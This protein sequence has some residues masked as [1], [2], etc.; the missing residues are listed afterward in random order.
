[1]SSENKKKLFK[2]LKKPYRFL[3]VNEN[4]FEERAS[5][6]LTPINT[7]LLFSLLFLVFFLISYF[8]IDRSMVG[9]Y[10]TK[11]GDDNGRQE[12]IDIKNK[13]D[14]M[15]KQNRI[16][17]R[18]RNDIIKVLKGEK[19]KLDTSSIEINEELIGEGSNPEPVRIQRNET[20]TISGDFGFESLLFFTPLKGKISQAFDMY[21]HKAIDITPIISDESVK[22]TLDGT[23]IFTGWTYDF[24]HVIQVQ[25]A[26]NLLSVYKHNSYLHKK[27]G[28][29]VSAGEVI[30]VAGNTGE[31]TSGTHLHFELWFNGRPLDPAKFIVF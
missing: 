30:A 29:Y 1:M 8:I 3:I 7:L 22:S 28:D 27:M 2:K 31:L 21:S 14:Q 10:I 13:F 11:N 15:E 12:L 18:R 6:R 17:I 16:E 24:G 25:H 23:V 5:F 20:P 9:T 19:T 26:N 4:T